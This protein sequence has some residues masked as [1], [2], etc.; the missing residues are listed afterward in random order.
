MNIDCV[1]CL[2]ALALY[3]FY[4]SGH[5]T[6]LGPTAYIYILYVKKYVQKGKGKGSRKNMYLQKF[7]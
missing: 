3:T 2:F 4:F 5:R 7:V 1:L 6:T